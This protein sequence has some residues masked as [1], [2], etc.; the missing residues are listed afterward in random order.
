M[1]AV[2]R[3]FVL[4]TELPVLEHELENTLTADADHSRLYVAL[5]NA[6]PDVSRRSLFF[7]AGRSSLAPEVVFVDSAWAES[8]RTFWRHFEV[9]EVLQMMCLE[10]QRRDIRFHYIDSSRET[11]DEAAFALNL[12]GL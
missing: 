8:P 2:A 4:E 10:C 3:A 1:Q 7:L 11:V 6:N 12:E 9:R 5:W